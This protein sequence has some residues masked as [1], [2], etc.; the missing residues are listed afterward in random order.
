MRNNTLGY[1]YYQ[2]MNEITV[3]DE[4]VVKEVW[5]R[6]MNPWEAGSSKAN[7]RGHLGM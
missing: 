5:K 3:C 6:H 4:D 1:S 2:A 7:K